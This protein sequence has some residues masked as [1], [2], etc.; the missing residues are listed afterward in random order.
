MMKPKSPSKKV[1][2]TEKRKGGG[3]ISTFSLFVY[4]F[5]KGIMKGRGQIKTLLEGII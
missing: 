2:I 4:S 3:D 5:R 1:A